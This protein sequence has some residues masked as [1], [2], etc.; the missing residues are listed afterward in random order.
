[1]PFCYFY[2]LVCDRAYDRDRDHGRDHGHGR[3]RV[4]DHDRV[5]VHDHDCVRDHDRYRDCDRYHD[6]GNGLVYALVY[7][8]D[9]HGR[10]RT[11]GDHVFLPF[12]YDHGNLNHD[13]HGSALAY[14]HYCGRV[15]D[16]LY[17]NAMAFYQYFIQISSHYLTKQIHLVVIYLRELYRHL[18]EHDPH[19]DP[20][21][22]DHNLENGYDLY[23]R[24]RHI[25]W[26]LLQLR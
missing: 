18:N 6:H 24:K 9:R 22:H 23:L 2:F 4:R 3:D 19:G 5:R 20:I 25:L 8:R 1:M 12:D 21:F 13:L 17:V 7:G 15:N 10:G 16:S 11:F 26:D 14:G